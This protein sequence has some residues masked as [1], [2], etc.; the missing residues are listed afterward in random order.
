MVPSMKLFSV[1]KSTSIAEVA[2]HFVHSWLFNYG[3]SE[4]LVA[5]NGGCFTSS[6]FQ[7][8]CCI[9][10][11]KHDHTTAYHPQTNRKVE[12]YSRTIQASLGTYLAGH[13]RNRDIFTSAL[14]YMYNCQPHISKTLAPFEL[15][16]SKS[17]GSLALKSIQ[18]SE[19]PRGE[20]KHK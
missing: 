1:P 10:S 2:K 20:F 14:T 18:T 4:Q 6:Y 19:E 8:V 16:I 5:N 17:P 3:P 13:P 9:L 12:R 7:K 15:V 11:T